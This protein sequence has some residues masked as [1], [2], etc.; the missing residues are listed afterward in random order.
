MQTLKPNYQPNYEPKK[1]HGEFRPQITDIN[2]SS[3]ILLLLSE[4]MVMSSGAAS[5]LLMVV[6]WGRKRNI[7]DGGRRPCVVSLRDRSVA[8]K[9]S[10][11][12]VYVW[13]SFGFL[14]GED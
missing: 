7:M 11:R 13:V 3:V 1:F 6:S 10:E 5:S 12:A 4:F 9:E 8:E 14:M 2:I